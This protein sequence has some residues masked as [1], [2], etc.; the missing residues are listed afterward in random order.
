M[1]KIVINTSSSIYFTKI[2][3]FPR[4]LRY[5]TIETTEEIQKEVNEGKD[6]GYKDAQIIKQYIDDN[7]IHIRKTKCNEIAKEFGLKNADASVIALAE[8]LSCPIAT[9]DRQLEKVC[10]IRGT[11]VTNAAVLLYYLWCKKEFSNEQA[12]L[13]LDLLVRSG[14]NKEICF[15]IKRRIM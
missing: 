8:E 5:F 6:I 12:Y 13:L 10:L 11:K 9:E 3:L 4:L 15:D 2:G 14:Y 7:D 1:K